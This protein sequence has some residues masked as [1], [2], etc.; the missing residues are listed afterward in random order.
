MAHLVSFDLSAIRHS[1]APAS[2]F[3]SPG[4]F[5]AFEAC[6]LARYAGLGYRIKSLLLAEFDP[7]KDANGQ[8]AL[9]M[10]MMV[11]YFVEGF[12]NRK[13]D[14]PTEDRSNLRKYS[15]RLHASV[16]YIDFF[17]HPGTGR[18]WMEVPY[19]D[20]LEKPERH[21]RLVPC[22]QKDYEFAKTDDIPE[23]W[24]RAFGRLK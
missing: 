20:S 5:S 24:W 4:G 23:R 16:K 14:F 15:V 3:P 9:L 8:S 13:E 21:N 10:A 12:Y 17:H 1:D 11:W 2:I 6:R 22:S 7:E 19:Q 18:W